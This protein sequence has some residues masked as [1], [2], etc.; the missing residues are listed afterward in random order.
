MV[1]I[2]RVRKLLKR[3]FGRTE[4]EPLS[5]MLEGM[6]GEGPV[7]YRVHVA[8]NER[9]HVL[10]VMMTGTD[11]AYPGNAIM[12]VGYAA[13]TLLQRGRGHMS[14][15]H[16]MAVDQSLTDAK[17]H[18]WE[19]S[20]ATAEAVSSSERVWNK[21]GYV[22]V[23]MIRNGKFYELRY[24]Q[25][26]LDFDADTGEP[27]EG[28]APEHFMVAS[29]N[30]LTKEILLHFHQTVL[31][32]SHR[33]A[34]SDFSSDQA[35]ARHNRYVDRF[36]RKFESQVAV[37]ELETLSALDREDLMK[38][39]QRFVEHKTPADLEAA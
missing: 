35:F 4:V 2:K 32:W 3:I 20:G 1:T 12:M 23:Y 19:W 14:R 10:S 21:F 30:E 27:T 24:V 33:W 31:R 17:A 15:L 5:S 6:R 16:A 18:G 8:L 28:E 39:G 34:R 9:G 26:S 11:Q 29:K 22:R 36:E 13:T 25:P 37:G 38:G 7:T